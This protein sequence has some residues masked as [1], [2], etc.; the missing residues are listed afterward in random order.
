VSEGEATVPEN[1]FERIDI[2]RKAAPPNQSL[3]LYFEEANP[4]G[5]RRGGCRPYGDF[6]RQGDV[7]T[8]IIDH[9]HEYGGTTGDWRIRLMGKGKTPLVNCIERVILRAPPAPSPEAPRPEPERVERVPN[10][11]QEAPDPL[12]EMQRQARQ[13]HEMLLALEGECPG[14]CKQPPSR[15]RCRCKN[16]CGELESRCTCCG[17]CG[18]TPCACRCAECRK[19]LDSPNDVENECTC[20][21]PPSKT[22]AFIGELLQSE[23]GDKLVGAVLDLLGAAR[24]RLQYGPRPMKIKARIQNPGPPRIVGGSAK[25]PTSAATPPDKK[26]S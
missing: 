1:G 14:G 4:K 23:S 21:A 26:A 25:Q 8:L 15:C 10:P 22:E 3:T 16:G 13:Y 19:L 12:R 2:A 7:M 20:E 6:P 11:V 24:K 5:S 9:M 17:D 18:K